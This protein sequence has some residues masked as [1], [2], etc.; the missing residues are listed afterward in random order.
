MDNHD[1]IREETLHV[2]RELDKDPKLNQR[3]LSERL[4]MSLGKTNYLLRELA[5]KG[6][7]KIA[8]F[9]KNPGKA[10]KVIYLL[11]KEGLQQKMKLTHHFLQVKEKEYKRLKEEYDSYVG[12]SNA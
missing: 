4:N 1:L 10:K 9:S 6:F 7:L 8:S 11:T 5:K 2:I 3:I 12:G